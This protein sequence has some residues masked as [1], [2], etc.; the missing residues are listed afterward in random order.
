MK[1]KLY[2]KVGELICDKCKGQGDYNTFSKSISIWCSR[3]E[4]TG[5][6]DWISN[7]MGDRKWWEA[8]RGR[9]RRS[10]EKKEV[11]DERG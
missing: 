4:G 5:K 10:I 9:D 7:A 2:L 8:P 1:N 11:F 6:V 3:C